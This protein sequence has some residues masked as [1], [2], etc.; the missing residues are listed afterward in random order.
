MRIAIALVVLPVLFAGCTPNIPVKTDFGTNALVPSGD[1]PPEFAQFNAYDPGT[2]ALVAQQLC[3]TPYTAVE[4]KSVGGSPGEIV[5][6]RGGC[7]EHV[8]FVGEGNP[9]PPWLQN[10]APP[11]VK[12]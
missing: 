6:G 1:T 11:W 7:Q 10:P 9:L 5:A 3:A 12:P 8:P 4:Q 2:G